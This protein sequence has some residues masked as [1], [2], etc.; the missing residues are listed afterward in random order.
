MPDFYFIFKEA[1]LD[2]D[3]K[4]QK[5]RLKFVCKTELFPIKDSYKP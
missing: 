2:A 5:S 1:I 3:E 4:L